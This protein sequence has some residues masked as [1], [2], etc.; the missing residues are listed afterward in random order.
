DVLITNCTYGFGHGVS[1]GSG[2]HGGVSNVVVANCSFNQT[3]QGIRI[4]S[5][6]DRGGLVQN[7]SYVNL[8]MTNVECPIL[9]Y[10]SYMATNRAYRA[11][12]KLTAAIAATYPARAA[13][14]RTPIYRNLTFSNIT[15]TVQPGHRAGLIWGLPEV[16][17]TNA[18]LENVNITADKPF[19]IYCARNVRLVDC[20][21]V[22]PD[23]VNK[24]S[25]TNA[26]VT[27]VPR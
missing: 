6:R 19:G 26:E 13:T 7:L 20:R 3:E 12:D 5:D 2:T 21:I 16:A 10:C 14:E 4:K 9:V 27:L 22:T 24:L 25:C 11:L 15:A 23:G 8:R 17:I 18:L 1:I